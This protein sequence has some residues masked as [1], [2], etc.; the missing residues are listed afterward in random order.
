MSQESVLVV[1]STA[2]DDLAMPQGLGAVLAVVLLLGPGA[3]KPEGPAPEAVA[4]GRGPGA[5]GGP[6]PD[7]SGGRGA[8]SLATGVFSPRALALGPTTVYWTT[9]QVRQHGA[10]VGD[11]SAATGGIESAPR[12]GGPVTEIVA[13]LSSPFEVALSGST[14]FFSQGGPGAATVESF[15]LGRTI[16]T[17]VATGET[18]PIPLFVESGILYWA[19]GSGGTLLV[20]SAPTAGGAKSTVG[21]QS[22]DAGDGSP[23]A[24]V[25]DSAS[26]YVLSATSGGAASIL[27]FPFA[28]GAAKSLWHANG[29]NPSD[30]AVLG[31]T[32]YWIVDDSSTGGEI[33]SMPTTGG[34]STTL[35][36]NLAS[37][38]KLAVTGTSLYFTEGVAS[39]AVLSVSTGGGTVTTLA[40]GLDYP[41]AIAVDD[42]VYFTTATTVGRVPK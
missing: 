25:A 38:A 9:S 33:L 22:D 1:G 10:P 13:G 8:T 20:Q 28:G 5:G 6:T 3:C 26:L 15:L 41:Y 31:T 24:M 11:A 4:S 30:L 27:A 17:N 40:S 42:A 35:A 2:F 37:P 14:L 7:A 34:T 36:A 39:G 16:L 29:A 19:S 21:S 12:A 32:L 23:V 18:P